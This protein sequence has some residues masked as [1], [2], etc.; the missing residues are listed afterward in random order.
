MNQQN[1]NIN[2]QNRNFDEKKECSGDKNLLKEKEC[3]SKS[4]ECKD[5]KEKELEAEPGFFENVKGL[6]VDGANKAGELINTAV[7]K[8]KDF[9]EVGKDEDLKKDELRDRDLQE[10]EDIKEPFVNYHKNLP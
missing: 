9:F 1:E 3:L 6:I 5:I 4:K 10:K 2:L 8:T 7:E